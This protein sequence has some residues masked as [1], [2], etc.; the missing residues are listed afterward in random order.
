MFGRLVTIKLK[1]DS[2]DQL[3]RINKNTIVPLLRAQKGFR[4]ESL[5]IAPSGLQAIAKTTWATKADAESY[6][7]LCYAEILI[8]LASVVEGRPLMEGFESAGAS[9]QETCAKAA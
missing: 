7:R 9:F 3:L 5:Y 6:G 4:D 8:A 2:V 1:V